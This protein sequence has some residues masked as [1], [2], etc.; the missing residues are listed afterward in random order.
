MQTYNDKV[1]PCDTIQARLDSDFGINFIPSS[2]TLL[3]ITS[4]LTVGSR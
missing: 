2:F 1:Q 4:N 3:S